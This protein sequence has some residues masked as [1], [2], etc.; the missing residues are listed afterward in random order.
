M[1]END[2][3]I[4]EDSAE[5]VLR[6]PDD[7]EFLE[8]SIQAIS[9]EDREIDTAAEVRQAGFGRD[10]IHVSLPHPR[11][12]G[13]GHDGAV[14]GHITGPHPLDTGRRQELTSSCGVLSGA[15]VAL[16]KRITEYV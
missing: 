15:G 14:Y 13:C 5:A 3:L 1:E 8:E 11:T 10:T 6:S 4:T 7:V 2:F 12:R 9:G 16:L